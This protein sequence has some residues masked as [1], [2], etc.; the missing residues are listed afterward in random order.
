[1]MA[2]SRHPGN[3]LDALS[4]STD[5]PSGKRIVLASRPAG[6]PTLENFR[7]E[8]FDVAGIADGQVELRVLYLSLDASLRDRKMDAESKAKPAPVN[9]VMQG[10]TI[11][12]AIRTDH[13]GV[14]AGER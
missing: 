13:T 12:P 8:S 10:E 1:M 3:S 11:N 2:M 9:G 14:S 6:E 7:L 4:R 5:M